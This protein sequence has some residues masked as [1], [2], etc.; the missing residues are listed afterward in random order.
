[1]KR[2]FLI[3]TPVLRDGVEDEAR[4]LKDSFAADFASLTHK[5]NH[6]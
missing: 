2:L 6:E 4:G 3:N 1:M 5:E